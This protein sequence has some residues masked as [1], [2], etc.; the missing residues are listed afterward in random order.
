MTKEQRIQQY[1]RTGLWCFDAGRRA[2]AALMVAA[3]RCHDPEHPLAARLRAALTRDHHDPDD[4]DDIR[5]GEDTENAAAGR[6]FVRWRP[7]PA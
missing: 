2:D 7:P 6:G 1:Y 3:I 5:S 4:A